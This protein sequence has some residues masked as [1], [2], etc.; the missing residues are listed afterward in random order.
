MEVGFRQGGEQI[1]LDGIH[2]D[3]KVLF[4]QHE[5]PAQVRNRVPLLFRQGTLCAVGDYQLSEECRS[6]EILWLRGDGWPIN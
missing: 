4:Q 3:L 5:V 1:E 2:R 6:Q